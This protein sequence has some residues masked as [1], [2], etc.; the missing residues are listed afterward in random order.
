MISQNLYICPGFK[1]AGIG[2]IGNADSNNLNNN[3]TMLF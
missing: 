1:L 3:E 2:L